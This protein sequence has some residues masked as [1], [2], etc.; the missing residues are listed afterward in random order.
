M[1]KNKLLTPILSS[2][3]PKPELPEQRLLYVGL[4][5]LDAK[6]APVKGVEPH[7][8][9]SDVYP[10]YFASCAAKGVSKWGIVQVDIES[11]VPGNLAPFYEYVK[12]TKR[13][14]TTDPQ[15]S[16]EAVERYRSSWRK[17][18]DSC[19]V[20]VYLGKLP[21]VSIVKVTIYDAYGK[22]ANNYV[23]KQSEMTNPWTLSP[24]QR[25]ESYA[26][27]LAL[28]RWLICDA[29][30]GADFTTDEQSAS[31]LDDNLHNRH[32]L[33]LYHRRNEKD[34]VSWWKR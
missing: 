25:K 31:K 33:D 18:L 4:T 10:G 7:V 17:S 32:G 19:G 34:L 27:N 13:L 22:L 30:N 24:E 29:V 5:E 8:V 3:T 14:R 21:P 20:I 2:Q 26:G 15:K 9:L 1:R 11:L 6:N 12:R 16:L 23:T 28:T